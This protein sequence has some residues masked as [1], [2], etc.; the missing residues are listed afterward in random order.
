M[1]LIKKKGLKNF[2]ETFVDTN[3]K[4]ICGCGWL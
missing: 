1:V 2:S 4:A 3:E